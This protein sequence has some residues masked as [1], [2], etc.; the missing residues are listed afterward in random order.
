MSPANK[1]NTLVS[2]YKRLPVDMRLDR[3]GWPG[4]TVAAEH[5]VCV[6]A[7]PVPAWLGQEGRSER[8]CG[9]HSRPSSLSGV[10]LRKVSKHDA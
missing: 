2:L 3:R 6:E 4:S 8:L 10:F 1:M 9:L 7:V 5:H